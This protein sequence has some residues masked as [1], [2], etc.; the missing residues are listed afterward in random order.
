MRKNSIRF[1]GFLIF[2]FV[3]SLTSYTNGQVT[4]LSFD[5]SGLVFTMTSGDTVYWA[6]DVPVGATANVEFWLDVNN[7]GVIDPGTDLNIFTFTQTDG[8]TSGNG[9]PPD[10]DRTANG[11]VVFY[12]RVGFFAGNY[13]LKF[14][15]NGIGMTAQGTVLALP[16]P[17]H[18]LSGTVTPPPGKSAKNIILQLERKDNTLEQIFWTGLTDSSGNY[19]IKMNGDSAGNWQLHLANNPFPADVVVPSDTVITITG[20]PSGLNFIILGPAAQVT[21]YLK[22]DNNQPIPSQSVNL[23]RYDHA[24]QHEGQTDATGFFQIGVLSSE[25]NG[26]TWN[27]QSEC[28]CNNGITTGQLITRIDLPVINV[29]DSLFRILV[30]YSSNSQITGRVTIDGLPPSFPI[31]VMA[32]SDTAFASCQVDSATGNFTLLVS[33]KIYNYN[34]FPNNLFPPNYFVPNVLAHPGDTAVAL[35][36]TVTSVIEHSPGLPARYAL[37]QNY[38]NPFNP[39]TTI[40]YD[41]PEKSAV[42]LRVY[43][44]LGR[45]MTR[46]VNSVQD[47]GS[48][49]VEWNAGNM[50]S[51]IYFYRLEATSVNH[52]G[53]TF[54]QVRKTLY[55]K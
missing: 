33:N 35:G 27:L 19:A 36:I 32:T 25:L 39:S 44:V 2:A 31:Q 7:N 45:E 9:G 38:P 20:N 47:P 30:V 49:S 13:L 48:K 51:G 40:N 42:V 54:T 15:Q 26:Q 11:H 24:V 52:P 12:Q 1:A 28:N 37:Q 21:G 50:A 34:V 16:S 29:N 53:K 18:T 8:D 6:Y 41:L 4:N 10:L 23:S 5:H 22:D 43:D 14:S 17:V 55:M 3:F 46:L